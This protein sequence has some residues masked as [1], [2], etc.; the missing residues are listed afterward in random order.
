MESIDNYFREVY[1]IV[2][3]MNNSSTPLALRKTLKRDLLKTMLIGAT[4]MVFCRFG[5]HLRYYIFKDYAKAACWGSIFGL[6]Y[7]PFYLGKK[8]DVQK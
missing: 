5:N 7:S 1:Y 4:F 2:T 3:T 8:I 6:A